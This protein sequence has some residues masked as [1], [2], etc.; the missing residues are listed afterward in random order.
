[1]IDKR[2]QPEFIQLAENLMVI[3]SQPSL[4]SCIVF[5]SKRLR[6]HTN[7][8]SSSIDLCVLK[9]PCLVQELQKIHMLW[10]QKSLTKSFAARD[11]SANLAFVPA[12]SQD[13]HSICS[14]QETH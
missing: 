7:L 2:R 12:A 8:L 10:D 5:R 13:T 1:M 11:A 9:R 3:I 6:Y 14:R 4:S